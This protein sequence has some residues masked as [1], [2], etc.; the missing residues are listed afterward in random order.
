MLDEKICKEPWCSDVMKY[1]DEVM[2]L[3]YTNGRWHELNTTILVYELFTKDIPKPPLEHQQQM[4]KFFWA[5]RERLDAL[6][7]LMEKKRSKKKLKQIVTVVE[8]NDCRNCPHYEFIEKVD[9]GDVFR[10]KS[11]EKQE[12]RLIPRSTCKEDWLYIH[13]YCHLEDKR[14]K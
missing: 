1:G 9:K 11:S 6:S 3:E 4:Q 12:H 2:S 10:C 8:I 7:S 13:P 14:E 5:M